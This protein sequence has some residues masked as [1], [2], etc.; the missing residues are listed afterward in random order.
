MYYF[1]LSNHRT[2][3]GLLFFLRKKVI[4]AKAKKVPKSTIYLRAPTPHGLV[5]AKLL[6]PPS[7]HDLLCKL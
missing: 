5:F 4:I 6:N 7:P 1:V 3:F 2:F